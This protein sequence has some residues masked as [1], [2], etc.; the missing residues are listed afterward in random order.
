MFYC[1]CLF[2]FVCRDEGEKKGDGR[3]G[4]GAERVCAL[5][6]VDKMLAV[7]DLGHNLRSDSLTNWTLVSTLMIGIGILQVLEVYFLCECVSL[8]RRNKCLYECQ[9]M[10]V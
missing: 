2:V 3:G 10:K 1:P 8:E 4:V 6:A 9:T 5:S 7:V